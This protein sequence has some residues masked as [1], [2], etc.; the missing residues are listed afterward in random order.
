[1]SHVLY[2]FVVLSEVKNLWVA[3]VYSNIYGIMTPSSKNVFV[4]QF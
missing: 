4:Q 1:M 3:N 2:L